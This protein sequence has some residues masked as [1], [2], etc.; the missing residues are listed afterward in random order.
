MDLPTIDNSIQT[1]LLSKSPSILLSDTHSN[2]QNENSFQANDYVRLTFSLQREGG[3]FSSFSSLEL[4]FSL[5]SNSSN[6]IQKQSNH[7]KNIIHGFLFN[8][9]Q[10]KNFSMIEVSPNSHG[11]NQCLPSK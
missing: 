10:V 1:E 4:L 6:A 5:C 7:Y 8:P 3:I 9:R 11:A 2:T